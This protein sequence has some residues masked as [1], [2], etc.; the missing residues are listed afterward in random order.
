MPPLNISTNANI[1][2]CAKSTLA[3]PGTEDYILF[4]DSENSYHLTGAKNIAGTFSFYD[5]EVPVSGGLNYKGVID[6]SGNPNFPA[7]VVG[8]LYVV[9]VAGTICGIPVNVGDVLI[10]KAIQ[11]AGCVPGNWT[12]IEANGVNWQLDGNPVAAEKFI[13]TTTAFNFPIRTNNV[14]RA[15]YTSAGKYGF[16]TN[17][18]VAAYEIQGTTAVLVGTTTINPFVALSSQGGAFFSEFKTTI[19]A[20]LPVT[21]RNNGLTFG[22]I[23]G[24]PVIQYYGGADSIYYD[25]SIATV[26]NTAPSE[27]PSFNAHGA[28]LYFNSTS[29]TIDKASSY[30]A[31][32][33][34]FLAGCTVANLFGFYAA[35][36]QAD[37]PNLGTTT[38]YYAYYGE[39]QTGTVGVPA[40]TARWGFYINDVCNNY[41]A[42]YLSIGAT[43]AAITSALDITSTL[44]GVLIPRMTTAQR[45]AIAAPANSLLIYNSTTLKYNYYDTASVSWFTFVRGVAQTY[46]PTNV[47]TDRSYDA[48]ATT[49]DE[50]ADVLGTLIIDLQTS[51]A[52]L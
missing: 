27:A 46:T 49:I 25:Q 13:G 1:T 34:N 32:S 47:T 38:N 11:A 45:N 8:D 26:F 41:L 17:T 39:N 3:S 40:A 2:V 21:A 18:P 33:A 9:S 44:R 23:A 30:I 31:N 16:G 7:A 43:T 37:L 14:Q 29:A 51:G 15:T 42:G 22:V 10:S 28:Q 4:Y 36:L 48:N 19:G 12:I 5:Y 24:N 20:G 50:L 35:G 52:I 6:A